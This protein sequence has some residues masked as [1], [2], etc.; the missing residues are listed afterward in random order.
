MHALT[1]ALLLALRAELRTRHRTG[2]VRRLAL[3]SRDGA[4]LMWQE[5]GCPDA[6][7]LDERR[8]LPPS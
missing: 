5:A 8:H 3:A 1:H 4:L 6:N 2:P 7:T